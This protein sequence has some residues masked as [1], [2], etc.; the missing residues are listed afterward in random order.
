MRRT[1]D[2]VCTS[3]A[4]L[5]LHLTLGPDAPSLHMVFLSGVPGRLSSCTYTCS[6]GFQ[7]SGGNGGPAYEWIITSVRRWMFRW[8]ATIREVSFSQLEHRGRD[9]SQ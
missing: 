1:V 7:L 8:S 2:L 9:Q 4:T 3:H 6:Q 5:P